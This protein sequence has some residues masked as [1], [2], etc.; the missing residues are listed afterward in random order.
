[1]RGVTMNVKSSGFKMAIF[2]A[3]YI[4]A[5]VNHT[6]LTTVYGSIVR[7]VRKQS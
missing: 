1:M 2:P 7:N 5:N 3:T 4:R 6:L